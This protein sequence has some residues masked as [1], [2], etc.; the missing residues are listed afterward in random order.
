MRLSDFLFTNMEPILR[1]WENFA[2]TILPATGGMDR[3]RLRD[4]AQEMLITIARDMSTEQ[5]ADEQEEK[6]RGQ[7]WR[8]VA[9]SAAET[10]AA[11][12]LNA[13]FT[14]DEL[15]SEY[16]ALRAT[17][18]RLWARETGRAD[19]STLEELIRFNEAL[20]QA[21]SESVSRYTS[22][23]GHARDLL[24]GAL[25]HDLRTP[26]SAVLHSAQFILRSEALDDAHTIAASRIVNS[27]TRMNAMVADLL[28]FSRTRL[29]D[30]LPV[31]LSSM[32]LG[33]ACRAAIEEISAFHPSGAITFE[34]T[35]A[36]TGKWDPTRIGQMLSNLL[37]NAV[38]HGAPDR[39]VAVKAIGSENEAVVT[40]HNEG[41]PIPDELQKRIFEPLARGS[42]GDGAVKSDKNLGLGL[43]IACQIAKAHRGSLK[44][45]TSNREGTIFAARLPRLP[46]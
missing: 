20:D 12:R 38:Q 42:Q 25:S 16:R 1:D 3:K 30:E 7:K 40:V 22:Q 28:D 21:L 43:Y 37:G 8:G 13:G 6:S 36:L 23:V 17:V 39:P 26:L 10:H 24:I 15:V 46:T 31:S 34:A 33:E 19:Q 11:E 2:S 4:H 35:G 32:D 27:A 9:D 14:L 5:T 29:G 45:A 44:L 18:I 41:P